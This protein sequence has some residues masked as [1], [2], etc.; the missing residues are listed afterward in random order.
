MKRVITLLLWSLLA[1]VATRASAS[2]PTNPHVWS[3]GDKLDATNLNAPILPI[4][5]VLNGGLDS[6]N[7]GPAGINATQ[8]ANPSSLPTPNSSPAASDSV[9]AIRASQT[10]L[11]QEPIAS[12]GLLVQQGIG[13]YNV[14]AYGAKCDGS[15]DDSAAIQAA[16]TAAA[17]VNGTLTGPPG[18]TCA[19]GSA[20]PITLT[21]QNEIIYWPGGTVKA[22]GSA[23][24]NGFVFS[25]GGAIASVNLLPN[26]SGF[27]NGADLEFNGNIQHV[28]VGQLTNAK[29]GVLFNSQSN[30]AVLDNTLDVTFISGCTYGVANLG[31]STGN[32]EGNIVN[33][34]FVSGDQYAVA[35]LGTPGTTSFIDAFQQFS[36]LSVDSTGAT[37]SSPTYGLYESPSLTAMG[38]SP[39]G[40]ITF[41]AHNFS[42]RPR[43]IYSVLLSIYRESVVYQLQQQLGK[44]GSVRQITFERRHH[45][46]RQ[47]I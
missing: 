13:S 30:V 32:L 8:I 10:G 40:Q 24:T 11:V 37:P 3:N 38:S 29:Y 18:V 20:T 16:N 19:Y 26:I 31:D 15:T 28:I 5:Q 43:W 12:L 35:I 41:D 34:N 4:Y 33:A 47:R 1:V 23:T 7:I 6:S 21:N 14:M 42:G 44:I 27:T 22:I 9:V 46:C 17:A 36:V 39:S 45:R 25:N 2:V